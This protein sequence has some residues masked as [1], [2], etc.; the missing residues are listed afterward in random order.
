LFRGSLVKNNIQSIDP[1]V[2]WSPHNST[3][4]TGI[5]RHHPASEQKA[6]VLHQNN[7]PLSSSSNRVIQC[8]SGMVPGETC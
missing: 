3:Y 5:A 7:L 8:T 1:K 6:V 4:R 2:M